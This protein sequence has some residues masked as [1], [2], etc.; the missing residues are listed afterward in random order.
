LDFFWRRRNGA[1]ALGR[2]YM[3]YRFGEY[4]FGEYRFRSLEQQL[5]VE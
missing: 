2:L 5:R 4:R 1:L 3:E